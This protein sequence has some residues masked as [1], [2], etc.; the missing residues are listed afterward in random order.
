M[1]WKHTVAKRSREVNK[2]VGGQG[3]FSLS[4]TLKKK[5]SGGGGSQEDIAYKIRAL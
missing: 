1:Y 2:S 5:T 3:L 4:T